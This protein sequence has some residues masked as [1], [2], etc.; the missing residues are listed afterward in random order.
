MEEEILEGEQPEQPARDLR[1]MLEAEKKKAAK[2]EREL[3]EIRKKA[4]AAEA[5]R[6]AVAI[7]SAVK[8]AGGDERWAD[9]LLRAKPDLSPEAV[10]QALQ[11]Y[12][13]APAPSLA[14]GPS[15]A[16]AAPGFP[17]QPSGGTPPPARRYNHVEFRQL[18][19]E[20]P[21]EARRVLQQGLVDDMPRSEPEWWRPRGRS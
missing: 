9:L 14:Q 8:D 10:P 18:L 4:E 12:G 11:E 15:L 7:R 5:E 21:L 3:A 20:S 19:A 1:A 6:R 17:F 2:L 13:L 16:P